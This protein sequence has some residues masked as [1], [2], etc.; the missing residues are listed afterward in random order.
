MPAVGIKHIGELLSIDKNAGLDYLFNWMCLDPDVIAPAGRSGWLYQTKAVKW[1]NLKVKKS[2]HD[3]QER[4]L[5]TKWS[6]Q[7][8]A[9]T[10][11][12]SWITSALREI[13][14]FEL[15]K[16]RFHHPFNRNA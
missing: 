11:L 16:A 5:L 3:Y 15:M 2:F 9:E 14:L 1:H 8:S 6:R 7:L 13:I 10:S 4:V 12:P